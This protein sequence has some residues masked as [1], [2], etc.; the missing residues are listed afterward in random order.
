MN[1]TAPIQPNGILRPYNV[2]CSET[3][4][5]SDPI[6]VTTKDNKT[7]TVGVEN[8]YPY[9]EYW[10][11]VVASTIPEAT[12]NQTECERYS[13]LSDPVR[14]MPSGKLVFPSPLPL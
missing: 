4:Q 3:K 9:R 13:H 14:T 7:T 6:S 1:W 11:R 2:T 5:D 10:C 12:Q 8:L